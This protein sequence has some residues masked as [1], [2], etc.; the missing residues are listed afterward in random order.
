M[1]KLIYENDAGHQVTFEMSEDFAKR[2]NTDLGIKAW[3]EVVNVL[4][5]EII[6]Q[7]QGTE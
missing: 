1:A 7:S 5:K 6:E 4:Q 2:L 3:A